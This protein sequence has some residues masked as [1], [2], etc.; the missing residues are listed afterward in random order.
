M[1][2]VW[3]LVVCF[4]LLAIGEAQRQKRIK[5]AYKFKP[6]KAHGSARFAT[7]KDLKRAGLFKRGGLHLGFFD[8]WRELF[9]N[10]NGHILICAGARTGKLVTYLARL[11]M[12]LPGTPLNPSR[13]KWSL[14]LFDP[15]C[16]ISTICLH[17]LK[18]C[19]WDVYVL[20][21]YGILLDHLKGLKQATFNP[22]SSLNPKSGSFHAD[23]AKLAEAI[24]YEESGGFDNHWIESA[25]QLIAGII[26][27]LVKYGAPADRNL[28]A[29][30]NV[31]TSAHGHSVPDFCREVMAVPGMDIY[32]RQNLGR[33][34]APGAEDNKELNGNHFH[35]GHTD[36][37]YHRG[38]SRKPERRGE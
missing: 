17:W 28:V 38:D 35:G 27:A 1:F 36:R 31:I 21:P 3:F 34:A 30:R 29:V 15:K 13:K 32:I 5:G 4:A 22:M 11:V 33:F 24:C 6:E 9:M 19:G 8:G 23:C 25:R 12:T 14:V 18:A 7:K 16:E 26:A 37:L 10:N 2:W 20:N